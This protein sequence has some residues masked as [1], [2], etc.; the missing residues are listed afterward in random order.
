[1]WCPCVCVCVCVWTNSLTSPSVCLYPCTSLA[2]SCT[3]R[4]GKSR[5]G[6]EYGPLTDLPDWSLEGELIH[7]LQFGFAL[8]SH[9]HVTLS[10]ILPKIVNLALPKHHMTRE[11][12]HR[13]EKTEL[14][15]LAHSL[16]HSLTHA[17]TTLPPTV[18]LGLQTAHQHLQHWRSR[19]AQDIRPGCLYV[20]C[21]LCSHHSPCTPTNTFCLSSSS[22]RALF[23]RAVVPDVL[24]CSSQR[25][26]DL[27]WLA[28]ALQ[29]EQAVPARLLQHGTVQGDQ[30]TGNGDCPLEIICAAE[31]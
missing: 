25:A 20:V 18:V 31:Y 3:H 19:G 30:D 12:Q 8:V 16:T 13:Q 14:S 22:C 1:V 24:R 28:S 21:S 27:A 17:M 10:V 15:S 6:T 2:V 5:S 29:R 9:L 4:L 7:R 26:H 11:L 23:S